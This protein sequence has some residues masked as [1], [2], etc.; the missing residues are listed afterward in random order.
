MCEVHFELLFLTYLSACLIDSDGT[1][2][3]SSSPVFDHLP[4]HEGCPGPHDSNT[5]Y[6]A[7][8]KVSTEV[9]GAFSLVWK[10]ESSVHLAR[11]CNQFEPGNESGLGWTVIGHW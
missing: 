1:I 4:D 5:E 2:S 11:F 7:N 10:C 3:P 9:N 8:D 6:S